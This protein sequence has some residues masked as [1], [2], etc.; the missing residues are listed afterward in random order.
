MTSKVSQSVVATNKEAYWALLH[1][2]HAYISARFADL[3]RAETLK[4]ARHR[5]VNS[6]RDKTRWGFLREKASGLSSNTDQGYVMDEVGRQDNM[7]EAAF[8]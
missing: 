5:S 8:S 7:T 1:S 6:E 4:V 3:P 2:Q